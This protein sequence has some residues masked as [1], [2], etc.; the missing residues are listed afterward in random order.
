MDRAISAD[1]SGIS[2]SRSG[3]VLVLLFATGLVSACAS[4]GSTPHPFPMPGRPSRPSPSPSG[5]SSG[6]VDGY[7][8]AGTALALRGAPYRNGGSDPRGFDC[9][10]LMW[11]VFALHGISVPR[12]V[13]GQFKS[14]TSVSADALQPGDLVFFRTSGSEPSHVGMI[15]GG[16]EF[17]HA[18]TSSG[19]VR[20]ERLGSG[21]WGPRYAGA[22]RITR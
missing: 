2:M 15:I 10:G 8:I 4:T 1:N 3:T 12:N 13:A 5:V 7:A 22:R 19:Q 18:P 6:S 11:Y 21:Y 16:D 20:V 9:S 17:V 14:G